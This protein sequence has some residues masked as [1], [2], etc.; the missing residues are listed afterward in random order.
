MSI[1]NALLNELMILALTE[2]IKATIILHLGR[3]TSLGALN[4]IER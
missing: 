1:H 4:N 3:D 2:Y